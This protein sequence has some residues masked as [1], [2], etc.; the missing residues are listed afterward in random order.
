[1]SLSSEESGLQSIVDRCFTNEAQN[2]VVRSILEVDKL[3]VPTGMTAEQMVQ[4]LQRRM[5]HPSWKVLLGY[6]KMQ[7]DELLS[8]LWDTKLSVDNM[9]V[10]YTI[11]EA[12]FDLRREEYRNFGHIY[13]NYQGIG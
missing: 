12:V 13:D 9:S 2:K 10:S 8:P 3:L 1:M 11:E 6:K 7:R 5:N 4:G